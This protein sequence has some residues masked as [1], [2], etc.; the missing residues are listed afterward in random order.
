V[1]IRQAQPLPECALCE[2]PMLRETHDANGGLCT[3]C[4]RGVAETVR[5]LP[6][7]RVVDLDAA[8]R[9]RLLLAPDRPPMVD[10]S[11]TVFVEA[12][13]PPVPGQLD[14]DDL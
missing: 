10:D 5:M 7:G 9:Q 14:L 6:V 8:R 3:A 1:T 12:Y 4:S 13:R 11:P 2:N